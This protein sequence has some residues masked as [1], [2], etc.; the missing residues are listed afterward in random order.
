MLAVPGG[1]RTA[2]ILDCVQIHPTRKLFRRA[3]LPRDADPESKVDL[4]ITAA[5]D[6]TSNEMKPRFP[7][8]MEAPVAAGGKATFRRPVVEWNKMLLGNGELGKITATLHDGTNE[9]KR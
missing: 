6:G 3:L 5:T 4:Q 7:G 8:P 2:F 1:G 9:G